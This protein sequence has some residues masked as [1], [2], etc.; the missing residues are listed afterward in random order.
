M[1]RAFVVF[2][3]TLSGLS[4]LPACSRSGSPAAAPHA[5]PQT[6][7]QELLERSAAA[8]AELRRNPRFSR[9]D[10]ALERA[11]AVLIFPRLVKASLIIGGEGGNGVLVARRADGSWSDPAFYS[12]G[13]PSVGLQVGYQE[14]AVALF[15]M[16]DATLD[17][18]LHSSVVLGGK[19][20]A[21]LGDL[22]DLDRTRADVLS[23][24]IYQVVDAQGAFAG[25]S[26]DG[27]VIGA[28]GERNRSYYGRPV[29][30][31]EIL[32][33]GTAPAR[34]APALSIALAPRSRQSSD[35]SASNGQ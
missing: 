22:D 9:I 18:A 23:A 16:D 12:L 29:T 19:A 6:K 8:F 26:L 24:N 33:D 21:T 4:L 25:V 7:E 17:R 10:L 13:S 30:P 27:Y 15:I 5:D 1:T 2:A 31:R 28:R 32:L 34:P 35:S 14:A 3:I 20:G 11:R